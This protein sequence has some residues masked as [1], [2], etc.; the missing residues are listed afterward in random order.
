M[1][2]A[3]LFAKKFTAVNDNT[4]KIIL[5]ARESLLVNSNNPWMKNTGKNFDVVMGSFD[6]AKICDFVGLFLLDRLASVLGKCRP[7]P[8]QWAGCLKKQFGPNDGTH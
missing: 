7:L 6:G 8:R 5:D 3:I 2:N 4:V 1:K